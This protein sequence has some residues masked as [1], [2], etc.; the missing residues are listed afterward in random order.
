[1][2]A[3][4]FATPVTIPVDEPTDATAVLL[5]LHVPPAETSLNEPRLPWHTDAGPEMGAGVPFTDIG[6]IA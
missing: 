5:L 1:M 2:V 6:A 4:P 3:V